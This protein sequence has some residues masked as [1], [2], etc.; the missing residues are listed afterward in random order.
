MQLWHLGVDLAGD[1]WGLDFRRV[2]FSRGLV[3]EP[4]FV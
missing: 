3:T 2:A 1:H 4:E